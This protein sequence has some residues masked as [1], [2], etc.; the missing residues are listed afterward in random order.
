MAKAFEKVLE[1]EHLSY[2]DFSERVYNQSYKEEIPTR[3]HFELTF[4]CPLHCTFC[5]CTPLTSHHFFKKELSTSEVLRILDEAA[6]E[7]CLWMTFSGGDP[8]IRA[9]FKTIYDHTIKLGIIPTIFASG[10]IMSEGWIDHLVKN[11]PLKIE[12]PL[13][14]HQKEIHEKVAGK[15]NSFEIMI[16][17]IKKMVQA[18]L[19][20]KIKSKILKINYNEVEGLK[21]FIEDD[22]GLSFNPNYFLFSKLDGSN[23]H[24]NE[25]LT[26]DQISYLINIYDIKDFQDHKRE[27]QDLRTED[28]LERIEIDNQTNMKN[29]AITKVNENKD[30]KGCKENKNA[31]PYLEADH[32][33]LFRCAAGVNSFYIN[34]YG[35][36]NLCSYIRFKSYDLKEGS[37]IDGMKFLKDNLL[38]KKE[39]PQSSCFDC[40]IKTTCQNCPAHAFFEEGSVHEK[41]RYLC[42]VNQHIRGV[43][44]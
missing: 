18:G 31:E 8:F 33:K 17:N 42:E 14:G 5:Y 16:R 12:I 27:G 39:K 35:E 22:L 4:R 1:S 44:L 9:D 10:F 30:D 26:P 37:L 25:R 23:E 11:P 29:K 36:L 3:G 7:G 19:P 43:S 15:K 13:Y 28:K 2:G 24:L 38:E 20:L 6:C 32:R 40:K 21:K 34:P 41:S